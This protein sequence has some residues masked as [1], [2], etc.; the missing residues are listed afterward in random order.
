MPRLEE[1]ASV[2]GIAE[3][4]AEG[5]AGFFRDEGNRELIGRL[6]AA[7]LN[8][9]STNVAASDIFAG[10][11]FV[12]TGTL[13]T[14]SRDEAAK[15]IESNGGKVASSV[16]KKTTYLVEGE[17]A[18]SKAVKARELGIAIISEDELRSMAEG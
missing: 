15:F 1:L 8:F 16:S 11:T 18:G 5:I 13:P 3:V 9:V 2:E 7:G 10:K 6:K 12:I 4:S 14:M 17:A